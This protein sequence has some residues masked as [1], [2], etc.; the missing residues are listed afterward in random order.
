MIESRRVKTSL[1]YHIFDEEVGFPLRFWFS[2]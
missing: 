1:N 2:P